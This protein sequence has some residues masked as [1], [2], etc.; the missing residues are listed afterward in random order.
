[1]WMMGPGSAQRGGGSE[2]K[3]QDSK[4]LQDNKD[5]SKPFKVLSIVVMRD[6][7]QGILKMSQSDYIEHMLLRFNMSECNPI[8]MPVDKGSHLQ[9]GE[10]Q[11]YKSEKTYQALTGSLTYAA[12][13]T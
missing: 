3:C 9:D 10:S 6:M 13:L 8:A 5:I 2:T 7:H 11:I 1:M 12:M 4:I